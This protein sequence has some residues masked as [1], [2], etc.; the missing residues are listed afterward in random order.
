MTNTQSWILIVEVG[1]FT[2]VS[3]LKAIRKGWFYSIGK[4][5]R[6]G[7]PSSPS[8]DPGRDQSSS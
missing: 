2:L 4:A 3:V 1:I 7:W 8:G 6:K 5:I